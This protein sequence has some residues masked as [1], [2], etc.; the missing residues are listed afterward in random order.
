MVRVIREL[1]YLK[2]AIKTLV[3]VLKRKKIKIESARSFIN[4]FRSSS[5]ADFDD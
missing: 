3:P 4:P 5:N 2:I 1:R